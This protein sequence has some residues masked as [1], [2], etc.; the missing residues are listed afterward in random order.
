MRRLFVGLA[1]WCVVP[2]PAQV[3]FDTTQVR[4]TPLGALV[5]AA[6][7]GD[8]LARI[9]SWNPTLHARITALIAQLDRPATR[10]LSLGIVADPKAAAGVVARRQRPTA[11]PAHDVEALDT[12]AAIMQRVYPI[13]LRD[14]ARLAP[15]SIA[16]LMNPRNAW[17]FARRNVSIAQSTEKLR[18][19]ERKYGPSTPKLNAVEVLLN[20]GAQWVPGFQPTGD[21]W[22]SRRE[23]IASYVPTYLTITDGK[24]H[25]VTAAELGLRSYIWTE[26]W[27]GREGGAFRPGHWSIGIALAGESDGALTSPFRG[28]SRFGAFVGWGDAKVAVIGGREPRVLVTRQVQLVPWTF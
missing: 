1:L 6:R 20:F 27:G 13:V 23:L 7:R 9:A 26:G 24:A 15:D 25:A 17:S 14:S 28:A 8:S 2:L 5:A 11:L 21:G 22:P 3:R 19:F 4:T 10:R 12:L 18:R 16:A